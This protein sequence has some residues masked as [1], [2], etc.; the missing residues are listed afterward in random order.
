V[1]F[2]S[3]GSKFNV[4]IGDNI[5]IDFRQCGA[6]DG[7]KDIY[8]VAGYNIIGVMNTYYVK[9]GVVVDENE[10]LTIADITI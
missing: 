3:G 5:L 4:N 7:Y 2:R 1:L 8:L 10:E 6:L 9:D